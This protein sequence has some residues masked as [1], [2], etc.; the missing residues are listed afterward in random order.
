MGTAI[1]Q[2]R[3]FQPQLETQLKNLRR[4][5][6]HMK[7]NK[8]YIVSVPYNN[9]YSIEAKIYIDGSGY[10]IS[11]FLK[12]NDTEESWKIEE[13]IKAE[14]QADILAYVNDKVKKL[15]SLNYFEKYIERWEYQ[16]KI[17]DTGVESMEGEGL[18]V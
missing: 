18:Y 3:K 11:L 14:V 7:H 16:K 13:N 8:G 4:K 6:A 15:I 2:K 17:F 12:D 10:T 9:Q 1:P 5:D